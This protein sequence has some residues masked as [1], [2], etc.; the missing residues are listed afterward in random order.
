MSNDKEIWKKHNEEPNMLISNKGRFF[1]KE[2]NYFMRKIVVGSTR[3]I[4]NMR[5]RKFNCAK[6]VLKLFK[7][8]KNEYYDKVYYKDGDINN[9]DVDNLEWTPLMQKNPKVIENI[10]DDIEKGI[11][12]KEIANKYNWKYNLIKSL[13]RDYIQSSKKRLS[14]RDDEEWKFIKENPYL[15]ISNYGRIYSSSKKEILKGQISDGNSNIR[16]TIRNTYT[17]ELL[18]TKGDLLVAEYFLENPYNLEYVYNSK[19]NQ[20]IYYKNLEYSLSKAYSLDKC[21][22]VI[23]NVLIDAEKYNTVV[24]RYNLKN[25]RFIERLLEKYYESPLD[26][27]QYFNIEKNED[28]KWKEFDEIISASDKGRFFNRKNKKYL[29]PIKKKG[30]NSITLNY[31]GKRISP[32]KIVATAFLGKPKEPYTKIFYKDGDLDNFN[33]DNLE[34]SISVALTAEDCKKVKLERMKGKNIKE[35]AKEFNVSTS[36][37]K[38]FDYIDLEDVINNG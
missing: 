9:M 7:E 13:D 21:M 27:Y 34:W 36:T 8:P 32:S 17:D 26:V 24:K 25:Q 22:K 16:Y 2:Q 5:D 19:N 15:Q 33:L 23:K 4:V 28:E 37:I 1:N 10:L 18:Y 31:S 29:K 14:Y 3:V 11:N 12:L 20:D 6:E 38:Q 35:V 30:S